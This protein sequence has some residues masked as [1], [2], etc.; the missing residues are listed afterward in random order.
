MESRPGS[1][2]D[3]PD[4]SPVLTAG[5]GPVGRAG[6]PRAGSWLY[7][8]AGYCPALPGGDDGTGRQLP[9]P[10]AGPP[11]PDEARVRALVERERYVRHSTGTLV[12]PA[13]S[14]PAAMMTWPVIGAVGGVQ[15]TGRGGHRRGGGGG[16]QEAAGPLRRCPSRRATWSRWPASAPWPAGTAAPRSTSGHRG[17]VPPGG[18]HESQELR[19]PHL[20]GQRH[21]TAARTT[22]VPRPAPGRAGQPL[23]DLP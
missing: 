18:L 16:R 19:M 15:A 22:S 17:A 21:K 8:S 10:P 9:Q 14:A 13:A 6:A 3:L 1:T 12:C 2:S 20:P 4:G 23:R 7:P 5:E 11:P